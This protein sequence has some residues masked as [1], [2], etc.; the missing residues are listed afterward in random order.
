[1][2]AS[3]SFSL[4]ILAACQNLIRSFDFKRRNLIQ[5]ILKTMTNYLLPKQ[6]SRYDHQP[7]P[8]F[9][10]LNLNKK[11]FK[12]VRGPT[13]YNNIIDAIGNTPLVK[14]NRIPKINGL[15]CDILVKCEYLNPSGSLKDRIASRMIE[16]AENQ[17]DIKPGYAIYEPSS[18]NTGIAMALVSAVKG[19]DCTIVMTKKMSDEKERTIKALG[20]NVVRGEIG[21]EYGEAGNIQM[22]AEEMQRHNPQSI[23]PNQYQNAYNPFAHYETTAEEILWDC[24]GKLE[25]LVAGAGTGGTVTGLSRKIKEQIPHCK[26]IGVDAKGSVIGEHCNIDDFFYFD[27]EGIG[28]DYKPAVI[29]YSQIDDWYNVTDKDS[30]TTARDLIRLE[31]LLVG[32]SSGSTV[33]SAIQA[34]K[35]YGLK[36]GDKCVVI[37]GDS[38]RNYM[39]KFIEDKW[40]AERNFI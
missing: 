12:P 18:G 16:E 37:L 36:K 19:Y 8:P 13:I 34:C 11:E 35:K 4:T 30:F 22:I 31:G 20:G 40:M 3:W 9:E 14:L 38:I 33:W 32:G 23:V 10:E 25:M 2:F 21:K 26:I 6:K 7:I 27:V 24:E 28:H 15:E 29:N 17:N 1:M 5:A 39:S